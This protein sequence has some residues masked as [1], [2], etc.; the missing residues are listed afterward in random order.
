MYNVFAV[1]LNILVTIHYIILTKNLCKKF[2]N[3]LKKF[4]FINVVLTM[5]TI[6][7]MCNLADTCKH[8]GGKAAYS[9]ESLY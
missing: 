2:C 3:N 7:R 8:L 1:I 6:F 5:I 9:E 4:G